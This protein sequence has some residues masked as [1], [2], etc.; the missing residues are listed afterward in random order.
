[1]LFEIRLYPEMFHALVPLDLRNKKKK[2]KLW[3]ENIIIYFL[4]SSTNYLNFHYFKILFVILNMFIFNY[5]N[6]IKCKQIENYPPVV[7][8]ITSLLE[9]YAFRNLI[10]FRI[11]RLNKTIFTKE[12]NNNKYFFFLSGNLSKPLLVID[13]LNPYFIQDLNRNFNNCSQ[14]NF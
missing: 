8:L 7:I 1:M 4:C 6:Q 11:L 13:Y 9:P 10:I 5:Y 3:W 2:K 14:K 12:K